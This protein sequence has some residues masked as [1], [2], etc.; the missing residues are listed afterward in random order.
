MPAS[1]GQGSRPVLGHTRPCPASCHVCRSCTWVSYACARARGGRAAHRCDTPCLHLVRGT[2][3]RRSTARSGRSSCM[4]CTCP[5]CLPSEPGHWWLPALS[6]ASSTLQVS[7]CEDRAR[8]VTAG[9][10]RGCNAP[11]QPSASRSFCLPLNS[12]CPPPWGSSQH[13]FHAKHSYQDPDRPN[14]PLDLPR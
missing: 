11:S 1:R 9:G 13:L 8:T 3:R 5:Q 6:F 14:A 4:Y 10:R 12:R 7:S 2:S